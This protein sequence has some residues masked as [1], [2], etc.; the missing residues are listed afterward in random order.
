M[1]H[2]YFSTE[3]LPI[4]YTFGSAA[5]VEGWDGGTDGTKREAEEINMTAN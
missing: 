3:V 5:K 1:F 2:F 4:L